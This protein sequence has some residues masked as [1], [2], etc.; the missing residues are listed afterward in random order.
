MVYIIILLVVIVKASSLIHL[1]LHYFGRSF[2]ICRPLFVTCLR[3]CSTCQS[4]GCVWAVDTA[5][6]SK[7]DET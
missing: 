2:R 4:Q 7:W 1:V 3:A 6:S 5:C